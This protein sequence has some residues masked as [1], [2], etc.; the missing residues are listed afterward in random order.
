M[1]VE[2]LTDPFLE[3]VNLYELYEHHTNYWE[4][5]IC[6]HP[7]RYVWDCAYGMKLCSRCG[8]VLQ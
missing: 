1:T 7:M 2:T 6:I 3:Y 4:D 8:A 5:R